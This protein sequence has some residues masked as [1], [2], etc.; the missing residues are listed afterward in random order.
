[1]NHHIQGILNIISRS[2]ETLEPRRQWAVIL[3]V[4][5]EKKKPLNQKYSIQPNCPQK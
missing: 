4:Q 1:M 5:K 2:S 3:K